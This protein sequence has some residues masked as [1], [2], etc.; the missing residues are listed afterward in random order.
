MRNSDDY[1]AT[2]L[3]LPGGTRQAKAGDRFEL[4]KIELPFS[5]LY[6]GEN[7]QEE[8]MR[9]QL[10]EIDT[11]QPDVAIEL[12]DIFLTD[13][14]GDSRH[15]DYGKFKAGATI[16]VKS[17][18]IDVYDADGV[19]SDEYEVRINSYTKTSKETKVSK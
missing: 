14:L 6:D 10:A 5:W 2:G 7:R 4:S 1:D 19:K 18:L 12:D 3:L 15:K 17:P 11:H 16:K 8:Y 13:V 9:S